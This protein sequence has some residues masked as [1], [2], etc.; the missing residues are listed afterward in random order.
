VTRVRDAYRIPAD[1]RV[2]PSFSGSLIRKNV[3][4]AFAGFLFFLFDQSH[5]DDVAILRLFSL[6]ILR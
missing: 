1:L 6:H 4:P 2:D 3:H 5:F